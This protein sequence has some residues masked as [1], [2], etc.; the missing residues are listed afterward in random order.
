MMKSYLQHVDCTLVN[1][2]REELRIIS[3]SSLAD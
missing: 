3:P 2:H 1:V